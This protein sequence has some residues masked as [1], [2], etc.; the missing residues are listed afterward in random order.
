MSKNSLLKDFKIQTK[1]YRAYTQGPLSADNSRIDVKGTRKG[2]GG[3]VE[4]KN[5]DKRNEKN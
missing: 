5:G 2:K 3:G 4:E 1:Y